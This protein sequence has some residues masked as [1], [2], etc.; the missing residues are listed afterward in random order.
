MQKGVQNLVWNAGGMSWAKATWQSGV[1]AMRACGAEKRG[2]KIP[3]AI[4]HAYRT[5]CPPAHVGGTG[6]VTLAICCAW[7]S[8]ADAKRCAK[9]GVEC[10]GHVMGEG[11]LAERGWKHACLWSGETRQKN[12]L[13]GD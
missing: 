3:W 6:N 5:I 10:G 13:R 4:S 8:E 2:K 7:T 12:P 11:N 9:P 1:G